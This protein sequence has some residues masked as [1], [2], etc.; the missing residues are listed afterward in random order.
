M[1]FIG[2][3]GG[4]KFLV[5]V[6][7]LIAVVVASLTGVNIEAY[8]ETIIGIIGTYL[9]GQGLADGLSKGA[10]SSTAAAAEEKK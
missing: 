7:G 5:A 6:F 10:T 1:N 4:R 9:L 8:Q 2:K 3:I